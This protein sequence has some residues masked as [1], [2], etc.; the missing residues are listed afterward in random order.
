MATAQD[1]FANLI[2]D[3]FAPSLR[4]LGFKGSTQEYA[5]P[6]DTC[7]ILI[8]VQRSAFS[9]RNDL[10]MTLNVTV[11]NKQVWDAMRAANPDHSGYRDRPFANRVYGSQIW[12]KRIGEL[13]PGGEDKWWQVK[14]DSDLRALNDEIV[15]AIRDH[16]L[17][18]IH[19][20]IRR[21]AE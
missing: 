10:R 9:D 6:D 5:F 17:P 21:E 3:Y 20:Q 2:R 7:W 11:A 12:H 1:Q 14:P 19:G 4:Q 16:A 18:A 15:S 13:L 8:G